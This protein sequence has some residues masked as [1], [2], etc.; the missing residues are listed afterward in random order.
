MRKAIAAG[1]LVGAVVLAAP[2][3]GGDAETS[4][5]KNVT[6]GDNYFKPR[7]VSVSVGDT[8]TWKWAGK[9]RHNVRFRSKSGRPKGCGPSGGTK[10]GSCKRAFQKA[11]SFGYICTLHGSMTGKVNVE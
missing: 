11:G 9:R 6:V 1:A 3:F 4:A 7:S 10:T 2:A 5:N 8:V